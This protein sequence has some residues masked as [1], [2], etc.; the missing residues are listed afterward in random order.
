MKKKEDSLKKRYI[1]RILSRFFGLLMG[2]I[3]QGMIPRGLGPVGYGI[4]SYIENFFS[5]IMTFLDLGTSTAFYNKIS[6]RPKEFGIISFYFRLLSIL[7]SI[8]IGLTIILHVSGIYTD[9]FPGNINIVLI[10]LGLGLALITFL[11]EIITKMMD[12]FAL[13]IAVEKTKMFLK[14]ITTLAIVVLFFTH[15]INLRTYYALQYFIFLFPTIMFIIILGKAG[16]SLF[17][18]IWALPWK[19]IMKYARE[20]YEYSSPLISYGLFAL[21]LGIFGRWLLQNFSGSSEQGYYGLSYNIGQICFLF[22]GALTPLLMRE[23][24]IAHH[25]KD[26]KHMSYLFERFVPALYSLSAFFACFIAVQ[27]KNVIFIF[28]GSTFSN[29]T[30]PLMIMIFYPVHQTYG[31]LVSTVYCATE[32][33]KL[34]RNIVIPLLCLS[35]FVS[36]FFLAP[37]HLYGLNL[38]AAGLALEMITSQIIGVN[39]L[40]FFISRFLAISFRKHLIH[41]VSVLFIYSCMGIVSFYITNI[42]TRNIIASFTVAGMI[43][44]LLA[45][46]MLYA[47]PHIFGIQAQDILWGQKKIKTIYNSLRVRS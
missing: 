42:I 12:A 7:I 2:L 37:H 14:T 35:L 21:A 32:Q 1:Y 45:I 31:Q 23:L 20:F 5:Q 8:V 39:I 11:S 46:I 10:Y 19:K 44:S 34:Y 41:Q 28:G 38:G 13:T 3:T 22:T 43:Y 17:R 24:S 18:N 16:H 30:I 40:L 15:T 9:F 4:F 27:A 36:Y 26:L 29:A 25:K 47:F 33:T 6:R